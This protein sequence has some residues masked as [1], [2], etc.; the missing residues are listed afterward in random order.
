M[1]GR[2]WDVTLTVKDLDKAVR[3]YED[4]LGF[5][6]KYYKVCAK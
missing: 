4:T 2:I 3:F 6:K 5:Q 1:L